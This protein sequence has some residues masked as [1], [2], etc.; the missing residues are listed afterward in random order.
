MCASV[1]LPS[2]AGA[3]ANYTYEIEKN[4]YNSYTYVSVYRFDPTKS[5]T[6]RVMH[7][8]SEVMRNDGVAGDVYTSNYTPSIVAS[9]DVV[10]VYQPATA[11]PAPNTAPVETWTVPQLTATAAAGSSSITG[12][13][14][15]AD[16][17]RV[18]RYPSCEESNGDAVFA[19]VSGGAYSAA[20]PGVLESGNYYRVVGIEPDNDSVRIEDRVPGD[21]F[22]YSINSE[23]VQQGPV[24][25][26]FP[27]RVAVYGLDNQAI[28]T[29][30]VVLRRGGSVIADRNSNSLDLALNQRPLPGDIIDVYRPQ[31]A[32]T[33]A[34]SLTIPTV[35][36][37]FDPGNDMVAVDSPAALRV[38]ANACTAFDCAYWS[39]RSVGAVP[40]G[41]SLF[42][43]AQPFGENRAF[44]ILADSQ[45]QAEWTSAD[46]H[47][48]YQFS[49]VPGDLTAPVGGISL[50]SKLKLKKIGKRIKFKLKSSEAGT[51]SATL[52]TASPRRSGRGAAAAKQVTLASA[53]RQAAKAGSNSVSLKVT[54]AGKRAIK[55]LIA[56]RKSQSATLAVTLTDAAGNVTTVVK[57][58]KLVLK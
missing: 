52:T 47:I 17:V 20:L 24:Q 55:K 32:P 54:K 1:L 19:N 27:F 37:T 9:G 4:I 30:R 49:A 11:S 38:T 13:S 23:L 6:V 14:G 34:S 22:C 57:S 56:Y 8:A 43:F 7:G 2:G 44:D 58:T 28:G 26:P 46:G 18:S 25:Y 41:R 15:S 29:T 35:P 48:F 16:R 40:A 45:V 12:M 51:L 21:A 50:A 39:E 3:E 36:A 31:G 5:W 42:S 33:P 53:A 10:E